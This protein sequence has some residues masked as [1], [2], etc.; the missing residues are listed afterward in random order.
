MKSEMEG[1]QSLDAIA[2]TDP[3]PEKFR[4]TKTK[5]F[6][7]SF[8]VCQGSWLSLQCMHEEGAP[9]GGRM[10]A[11][12]PVN[13]Q[14]L[15]GGGGGVGHYAIVYGHIWF[16]PNQNGQRHLKKCVFLVK[17]L[18]GVQENRGGRPQGHFDNVKIRAD[19]F[20]GIASIR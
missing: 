15:V 7:L 5:L 10:E 6:V 14:L 3:C 1:K 20:L 2:F 19:F 16:N 9:G 11:I 4:M 8:Y 12:C 13:T 17:C 18:V